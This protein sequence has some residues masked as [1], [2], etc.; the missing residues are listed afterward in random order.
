MPHKTALKV[1]WYLN[2]S[3]R[4]L[5]RINRVCPL[6]EI[7]KNKM[8]RSYFACS[9]TFPGLVNMFPSSSGP[10]SICACRQK[11]IDNKIFSAAYIHK[12]KH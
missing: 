11:T 10:S 6:V 5:E 1:V 2:L 9:P 12:N 4:F 7:K 3:G 8:E